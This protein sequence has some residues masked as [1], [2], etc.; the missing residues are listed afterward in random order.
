MYAAS[1]V[2]TP[3]PAPTGSRFATTD[4]TLAFF[5]DAMGG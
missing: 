1:V 5:A 3:I 4:E 2:A